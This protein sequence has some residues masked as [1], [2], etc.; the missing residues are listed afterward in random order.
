M[1][2]SCLFAVLVVG[3]IVWALV[4]SSARRAQREAQ[5]QALRGL[6]LDL[7]SAQMEIDQLTKHFAELQSSVASLQ[8]QKPMPIPVTAD[9]SGL[10]PT[11]EAMSPPLIL[12]P[13]PEPMPVPMREEVPWAIEVPAS[14][15][16]T[17]PLIYV[18]PEEE[19][20]PQVLSQDHPQK[21]EPDFTA[22]PSVP[23]IALP[24]PPRIPMLPLPAPNL[25]KP[26]EPFDWESLIGVKLFSWI[27]GIALLV[28]AVAFLKF[29]IEHGWLTAPVRL[30]I[31][32][33]TGAGLLAFCETER[34]Q[35]YAVTA[36]SL[37][38][39]GIAI[40]FSTFFASASLWHLLPPVAA[41]LC[42]A[43]VTAV[44]VLLSIRRDS[45][46]IA[47]LGLLGGFA[48]PALLSTGVD[49]PLG[50]FGYL[51]L[52]NVGLAWVGYRK[53][54]PLLKALSLLFTALYQL[55]WVLK[56]L[57]DSKLGIGLGIFLLFPVMA[58]GSLFLGER[59][60]KTDAEAVHPLFR[61]STTL[62][63]I[64][65]L[66]FALH[67]AT[68]PAYGEHYAMM[69][70]FLALVVAGLSTVA[71]F[72][73]PEWL[74]TLAAT[75]TL[76]VWSGWLSASYAPATWPWLLAFVAL[77]V[78]LYLGVPLL[79][80][81]LGKAPFEASGRLGQYAAP[82]LL[83]V[84]PV[85]VVLE[86]AT[87]SPWLCFGSMLGLGLLLAAYAIRQDER[88][89]HYFACFF[90][91]VA[92]VIWSV[93]HLS[94]E[95]LPAALTIYGAFALFTLGVPWFAKV[96]G[97][98]WSQG[99]DGRMLLLALPPL[100]FAVFCLIAPEYG[101]HFM[102]LFS[103]LA[104]LVIWLELLAVFHGPLWLHAVGG[105][106]TLL[107][108]GGWLFSSY[109]RG[110]WPTVLGFLALFVGIFLAGGV[111]VER[112][113]CTAE[114]GW[115]AVFTAPMLL[116][117][118]P[119]L[120]LLEPAVAAPGLLFGV[121][122]GLMV[123]LSAYSIW[124][125]E[126]LVHFIACFFV[127]L[128]EA[129]WS[130]KFL[131]PQHLMSALA[132]YGG[133]GLFYL[134]VP[135]YA[136]AKGKALKPAGSGA[137]LAF[138][139]LGLL[140]FLVL[141]PMAGASLWPLAI[142]VGMLNLGMLYEAS[143]GHRP[144]LCLTGM[145]LSWILLGCWWFS[146]PIEGMLVPA[147]AVLGAFGVLVVGGSLWL[148]TRQSAS[149]EAAPFAEPGLFLG[150]AGHL[151]LLA[152]VVQPHL[153]LPPWPWLGVLF[154][155]VLA[156]GTAALCIRRGALQLGS[157][158]ATQL[159]LIAWAGALPLHTPWVDLA[160][161]CP[162]AFALLG[163]LWDELSRLRGVEDRLFTASAG[164]GIYLAQLALVILGRASLG[165][166]HASLTAAH[167]VL[168]LALLALAWR[169]QRHGWALGL[170]VSMGIILLTWRASHPIIFGTAFWI[171]PAWR[172][173]L[174]LAAPFYLLLLGFPL[175]LEERAKGH[176][177]PFLAALV[178]SGLFFLAA[179]EAL[180]SGGF[181]GV[182]GA[183]PVVQALLLVPHL[184][185]LLR[186]EPEGE[187][188]LG[189]LA[190]V[191][192]GILAFVTLAIPL[193]LDKEWITLG[194]ALL[195]AALAWLYTRVPH[196]GLLTWLFALLA[197]VFARLVLNPAVFEYHAR[198]GMP[199]V[200]WYLYS[201]L[202]AAA[203]FFTA[204]WILKRT[205][206]RIFGLPR[207]SSL[208]PVGGAVLLFLLLNIEIA[209]SFSAGD[210]LTFNLFNGS[211][212]QQ[213]SYTIGWA[214]YAIALLLTGVI[215]RSRFTRVAA[216]V[217]L[218][219]TVAKAFLLDLRQLT[220]LYRVASFVGLAVSLALV[221]VV[222]QK[223][224]LRQAEIEA[225]S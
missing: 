179:W 188:D 59:K 180:L 41:F 212:A 223:F 44:A 64:P 35:K 135:V 34:A 162:V 26:S 49:N 37:T 128:A 217:M 208:L 65:P 191:A 154:V 87:A 183:L 182:I 207:L 14:A 141:G 118:F 94:V 47:L 3:L 106:F 91:I 30:T 124:F 186:L 122:L 164:I 58:F 55:G 152:V 73:G 2:T 213:L 177:L 7:S 79:Q 105:V 196:K 102:L 129:L 137:I 85:L 219:A 25:H 89:I 121:L 140:F 28:A 86:P 150:L 42:M 195:A 161:W 88:K 153:S 43:L 109:E 72:R 149:G 10:L 63:A 125:E 54:W 189:R 19:P 181:K 222:L 5:E 203:C 210:A 57:N 127:L 115:I 80:E 69:F 45:I 82:L 53:R 197:V 143:Q 193:Q 29:G 33:A 60:Q 95:R 20:Q 134:G 185:R 214:V 205:E 221:A 99:D 101:G 151:F 146:A 201:Y 209:D 216:I 24:P 16:A 39:A 199:V 22:A 78:G 117:A 175:V 18:A 163:L 74:H 225:E 32:L 144:A 112:R 77:F 206:D 36:Q 90:M 68:T 70:G 123:V 71:V 62:A 4:A 166:A 165:V 38:A 190:A 187:R 138:A 13:M 81:K 202:V 176:R 52:L 23:P 156:L 56:F 204:A 169:R 167:A 159:V 170:A 40:L 104:G 96:R 66:L 160:L 194:W 92:E 173:E 84:F 48:T 145:I 211:L 100:V 147:L 76:V 155:L 172:Q 133:F 9:L 136:Q 21:S 67:L 178:G 108:W 119:A 110:A 218:T 61:Q 158:L 83:M 168:G 171:H 220:G 6:R 51:A 184:L 1:E 215:S 200:N 31:G 131:S 132:I 114:S 27:A 157:V 192:G 130:S 12:K 174:I 46:F 113:K 11:Q 8:P 50:L 15:A 142:L 17:Q 75:A 224:A 198:S 107:A 148:R 103:F 98:V 120:V 111:L 126:G 97:R 93:R 116:F 139:S